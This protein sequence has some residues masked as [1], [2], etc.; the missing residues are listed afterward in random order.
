MEFHK[1]VVRRLENP[2][3]W[4]SYGRQL[5]DEDDIAAV[6]T[7]LESSFITTGPAAT[8]FEKALSRLTGAKHAIVCSNGTAALH[9]ACIGLHVHEHNLGITS[10]ITFLSSA[11]CVEFC[12]GRVDFVDIDPE[13]LCL[14]FEKLDDYC[15]NHEIPKVVIPVDFAGIPANL[16]AIWMLAHKYGFKVIEDAAHSIGSS[17]QFD[18]QEYQCGSCTH[19]DAAIFSFHP[20]KTITTGEGGAVLTN[21]DELANRI[22][23]MRS[24]GMKRYPDLVHKNEG[25]WYYEIEELSSNFRITDFQCA[26]GLSQLKKLSIFKSRRTE[27]VRQ[28]NNAFAENPNL[29]IPP[30]PV[31]SSIC[32]HLYPLRFVNGASTRNKIFQKLNSY[33]IHCQI[34]YIPVY[35]QPYYRD[36]YYF[37]TGK[38]PNAEIYYSQCL[39]LPLYPALKNDEVDFIIE[40]ILEENL[41]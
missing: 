39:S 21:D 14:S 3:Y 40:K 17:Y 11:N 10:P 4:I 13:T 23:M 1:Q 15:R 36:K 8:D 20:V 33:K 25:Q 34:H 5:I 37:P 24:H 32:Y 28:Y 41:G 35:W 16:P 38:C 12:K 19:S 7:A 22:R 30:E 26:L 29:I 2:E 31:G 6:V 18:G 27:I 9:L